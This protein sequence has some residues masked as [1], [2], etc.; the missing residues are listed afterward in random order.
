MM[1]LLFRLFGLEEK[2]D[3]ERVRRL[4]TPRLPKKPERTDVEALLS[5]LRDRHMVEGIA[6]FTLEGDLVA[7]TYDPDEARQEFALYEQADTEFD[8]VDYMFFR[9]GDWVIAHRRGGYVYLVRAPSYLSMAEIAVLARDVQR[10]IF[11]E[12]G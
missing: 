10:V 2:R 12:M 5:Y 4:A 6:V 11:G 3:Y 7:S 9:A 8:G 1:R